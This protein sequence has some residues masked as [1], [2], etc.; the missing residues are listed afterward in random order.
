[1]IENM[2]D[3]S[4][5]RKAWNDFAVDFAD[6]D[7][8]T[9][10]IFAAIDVFHGALARVNWSDTDPADRDS[11]A[12]N[13]AT[14]ADHVAG[15]IYTAETKTGKLNIPPGPGS[16]AIANECQ[17]V[18]NHLRRV[19]NDF[20]VIREFITEKLA[21]TDPTR[22][23]WVGLNSFQIPLEDMRSFVSDTWFRCR[24]ATRE[25]NEILE[26]VDDAR[27]GAQNHNN[28]NAGNVRLVRWRL[29]ELADRYEA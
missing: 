4:L 3:L 8:A 6:V 2:K 14:V 26:I 11:L 12:R 1:M 21:K 20:G 10:D 22:V 5:N 7:V 28:H 23:F 16:T 24:Q 27:Q 17:A 13:A 9:A 29:P 25:T 15:M 19:R 18:S